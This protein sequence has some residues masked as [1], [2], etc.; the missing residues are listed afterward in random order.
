[1]VVVRRVNNRLMALNKVV[2]NLTLVIS[3]YASQAGLDEEIKRRFQEEV[4]EVVRH[5]PST[6]KLFIG[7]AFNGHIGIS[8]REYDINGDFDFGVK[9]EGR[10][11]LLDFS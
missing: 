3:A 2:K 10:T 8:A 5:I 9:N 6:E 1:M 7:G 11:S 4:D